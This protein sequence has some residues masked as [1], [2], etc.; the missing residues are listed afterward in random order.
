MALSSQNVHAGGHSNGHGFDYGNVH[1]GGHGSGYAGSHGG[2]HGNGHGS[3]LKSYV[4]GFLL[5][6]VL[7]VIPIAAVLVSGLGRAAVLTV[8]LVSAVLQFVVQLFFFMHL[9]QGENARWNIMSLLLGV[10]ILLFIVVGSI[11]IMTFNAVAH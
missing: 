10:I 11:W 3:S 8:L 5:S 4:I 7:T 6:I 1:G 9:R 2:G